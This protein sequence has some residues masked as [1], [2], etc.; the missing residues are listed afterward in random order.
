M[1][2]Y[3]RENG[4][5]PLNDIAQHMWQLRY[6]TEDLHCLANAAAVSATEEARRTLVRYLLVGL[7]SFDEL[8]KTLQDLVRNGRVRELGPE[9]RTAIADACSRYHKS[10]E[11]HRHLLASIRH[12]LAAHRLLPGSKE[13]KRYGRDFEAWGAWEHHLVSLDEQCV[14]DR[15]VTPIQATFDLY[16]ELNSVNAARWFDINAE[17]SHLRIWTPI[18]F[19]AQ[20]PQ[21]PLDGNSD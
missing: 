19:A 18:R 4:C 9:D 5:W 21:E 3:F 6:V 12:N 17:G 2:H 13:R 11:P 16:N 15:W 1:S 20:A 8:A 10:M 7:Q 14:L